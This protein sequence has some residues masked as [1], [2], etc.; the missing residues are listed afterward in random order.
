MGLLV[1]GAAVALGGSFG[2][3][4]N[5]QAS[6][7]ALQSAALRRGE[8]GVDPHG[9]ESQAVAVGRGMVDTPI[10]RIHALG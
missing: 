3:A 7:H 2:H 5:A 6:A 1:P 8:E 9:F 4:V 10:Q